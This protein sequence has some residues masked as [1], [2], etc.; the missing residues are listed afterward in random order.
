VPPIRCALLSAC[1]RRRRSPASGV[2]LV[3]LVVGAGLVPTTAQA[4]VTPAAAHGPSAKGHPRQPGRPDVVLSN[5]RTYTRWTVALATSAIRAQPS[6]SS[7]RLATLRYQTGDGFLQS[8][9]LLRE[10]WNRTGAW[11]QLRIPMRPNG[12]V[13]WVPREALDDFQI[14]HTELVVDRAATQLTLYRWGHAV[15]RAPVGTGKPG[16]PTPAGHFWITEAFVSH[17]AFYGPYAFATSD[18]STLTDWPGGGIVGL[19]GTNEPA[20]VPGHPSHGCIRLHNS[21]I[22]RLSTMVPIGTP[23]LV[24]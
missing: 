2:A 16:T 7:P 17:N 9:V 23:L 24:L 6:A 14:V 19:H 20:L 8:Y 4:A 21:D 15:Y 22:M 1:R 5:E 3:L 11:V 10:R 12:K 13:G 18:Y